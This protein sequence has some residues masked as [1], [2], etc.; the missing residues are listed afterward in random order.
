MTELAN[1]ETPDWLLALLSDPEVTDICLNAGDG[2]YVD[3]GQGMEAAG[4]VT[5]IE[6]RAWTLAQLA[7]TGRS[8][9]AKYPFI[10]ATLASGHRMHAAFPPL[11]RP[12]MLVSLRRLPAH[13]GTR[14]RE[15]WRE[16]AGAY[17][18]LREA[19]STSST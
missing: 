8:W 7:Q 9:D 4:A 3:R 6:I 5:E 12:G 15:R 18:L 17:N 13:S 1:P 2:I 10:D 11:A 19:V 16:S 14:G